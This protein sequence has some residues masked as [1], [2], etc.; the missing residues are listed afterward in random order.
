M[1][2]GILFSQELVPD[3]DTFF[4][5]VP[6]GKVWMFSVN[7]CNRSALST[8][9]R[10]ALC[11]TNAVDDAKYIEFNAAVPGNAPLER[12]Q[13]VLGAG[14]YVMVRATS[15]VSVNGYGIEE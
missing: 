5:P 9:V 13:L 7:V 6:A 11:P 12:T 1:S 10:I 3:T 2:T 8:S 15:A 4:G 14:G